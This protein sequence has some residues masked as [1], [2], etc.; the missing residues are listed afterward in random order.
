MGE[1]DPAFIVNTPGPVPVTATW[2]H[3]I[4]S[5]DSRAPQALRGRSG[6][7]PQGIWPSRGCARARRFA[8]GFQMGLL[9]RKNADLRPVEFRLRGV[10]RARLPGPRAP[11]QT[12]TIALRRGD[13][14]ISRGQS[15]R[16]RAAGWRFVIG[17][18]DEHDV[19][20]GAKVIDNRRGRRGPAQGFGYSIELVQAGERV[21]RVRVIGRCGY[22]GCRWRAL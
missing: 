16:L 19:V 7:G 13:P 15:R 12:A 18:I 2:S 8:D 6:S 5:D 20:F 22:L 1:S 17:N 9:A 10:R 4:Q 11:L 3:E 14:G 21:G